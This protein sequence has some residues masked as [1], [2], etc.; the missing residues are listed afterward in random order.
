LIFAEQVMPIQ[1]RWGTFRDDDKTL[2]G[3]YGL[4]QAIRDIQTKTI[5]NASL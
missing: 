5:T 4:A 3:R 1:C 2:P